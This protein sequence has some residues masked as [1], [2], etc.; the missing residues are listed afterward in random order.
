MAKNCLEGKL[1]GRAEITGVIELKTGLHIGR[2]KDTLQIGGIDNPIVRDP[3]TGEPYI[4]GSSFK[5]KMR[6]F[7][8]KVLIASGD[9]K[10]SFDVESPAGGGTMI[11]R[12]ECPTV[13][14]AKDCPVCRLF[15]S[16][17]SKDVLERYKQRGNPNP[18]TDE[19]APT[20]FPARLTVWDAF[21]NDWSVNNYKNM[22]DLPYAEWK[23][24]N[25]VDRIT[26][27]ANPRQVER[28][29]KGLKFEFRLSYAIKPDG[30]V[31]ADLQNLLFVLWLVENNGLGGQTS[32][33]YGRIKFWDL[34]LRFSQYSLDASGPVAKFQHKVVDKLTLSTQP[35]ETEEE[36][37]EAETMSHLDIVKS[38]LDKLQSKLLEVYP[39]Q[40]TEGESDEPNQTGESTTETA[41][42]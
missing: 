14:V 2:S 42:E 26:A 15:G 12:H 19:E 13:E 29:A 11:Y 7:A 41:G 27:A 34:N 1:L 33:G 24:E 20:N 30:H 8:E 28:A 6:S 16:N 25:T 39:V 31:L 22:S 21:L 9:T 23:S 17:G 37:E 40:D 38:E 10:Y 4:P 3:F 35:E 36:A 32:R 5:G 18:I